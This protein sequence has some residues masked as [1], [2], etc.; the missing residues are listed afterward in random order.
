M[1]WKSRKRSRAVWGT[2]GGAAKAR[3]E[4]HRATVLAERWNMPGMLPKEVHMAT[5]LVAAGRALT[6]VEWLARCGLSS[7]PRGIS[8]AATGGGSRA[9]CPKRR[10]YICELERA[11]YVLRVKR[12]KPGT[13]ARTPD[14]YLPTLALLS[15]LAAAPSIPSPSNSPPT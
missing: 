4:K 3:A 7:G 8:G 13:G 6:R 14:L 5:V 2:R 10:I 12:W 9:T 11:G 15:A 1:G